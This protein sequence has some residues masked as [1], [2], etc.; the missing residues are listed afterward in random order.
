MTTLAYRDGV[1]AADTLVTAGD[2]RMGYAQKARRIGSLLY[3]GCGS[4]GLIDRLEAWLRS[5]AK[6]EHPEL[7]DGSREA[8]V[9]VFMPDDMV[10]WF[11]GDGA[12]ALR[13]EYWAAGSGG[14]YALGA[15]AMGA[16]AEQAVQ[17]AIKHSTGSGGDIT[18][19]RRAA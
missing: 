4:A 12:T 9:Y 8:S 6:G 13:S 14:D 7:K 1:L 5:G 19:L 11:H 16:T 10:L 17:A 15:M 18:V 3:A 2:G